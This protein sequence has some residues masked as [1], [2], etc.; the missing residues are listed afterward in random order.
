[1]T[2]DFP[3][4]TS[5]SLFNSCPGGG[6]VASGGGYTDARKLY[7]SEYVSGQGRFTFEIRDSYGDGICCSTGNGEY[8]LYQ[9]NNLVV[10]G[11]GMY[12]AGETK[13]F[14]ECSS[15]SSEVTI[16]VEILTDN[17]PGDTSWTI[18]NTCPGGGQIASDSGYSQQNNLYSK[19]I[20]TSPGLFKFDIVDSF[21][22][23]MAE[24][25]EYK[26]FLDNKLVVQGDG[27]YGAGETKYFG[28]CSAAS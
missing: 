15:A 2:D 23:G 25:G 27:N 13:Y 3:G 9:D 1:L 11:D 19:Q 26:L 18:F 24:G 5:W 28:E 7:S 4:D 20:T 16:L 8:K 22:D 17:W 6:E 10:Q 12:G 14:G 21:G